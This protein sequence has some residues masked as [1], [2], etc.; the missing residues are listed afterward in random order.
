[1]CKYCRNNYRGETYCRASISKIYFFPILPVP[2]KGTRFKKNCLLFDL[3]AFCQKHL[4]GVKNEW[5]NWNRAVVNSS[6]RY[7]LLILIK[8]KH[9]WLWRV[10]L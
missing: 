3:I 2:K 4:G 9:E 10:F 1:M 8:Y 5:Y 6:E 7:I